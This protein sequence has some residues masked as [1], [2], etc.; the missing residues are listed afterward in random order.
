MEV[1]LREFCRQWKAIYLTAYPLC[2]TCL[3]IQEIYRELLESRGL[4]DKFLRMLEK[5]L[6]TLQVAYA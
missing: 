2:P 4:P 1:Q 3:E 5:G 6:E